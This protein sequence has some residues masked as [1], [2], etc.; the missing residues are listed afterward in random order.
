MLLCRKLKSVLTAKK[1]VVAKAVNLGLLPYTV[2]DAEQFLTADDI[3]SSITPRIAI[4]M[5]KVDHAVQQAEAEVKAL[6]R[7]AQEN[8]IYL[9]SLA[10]LAQSYRVV[11]SKLRESVQL[12]Q[13]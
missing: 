5:K 3:G 9:D 6:E 7:Q 1:H 13:N 11:L 4:E 10:A 12:P 2:V 8:A